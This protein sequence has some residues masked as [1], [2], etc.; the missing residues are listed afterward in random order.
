VTT[1]PEEEVP[2][3]DA[4]P[5]GAPTV[6][7][8]GPARPATDVDSAP[9]VL[10][11]REDTGEV[12]E[13]GG[14][15]APA[16]PGAMPRPALPEGTRVGRYLTLQRLGQGGMGEVYSAYDPKLDRKVAL[17][18]LLPAAGR[19]HRQ[20]GG[21][22]LEP[23]EASARL[24]REAQ[25]MAR[26]SHPNVLP[27]HDV[28]EADGRVFLAMDLVEGGT[29]R[30]WLA[31]GPRPLRQVVRAFL[32]AGKG[33]AAAHAKG[34]VHRDFKPDNV[35]VDGEGR[36]Y[37]MDFG[38]ARAAQ[39]AASA[40]GPAAPHAPP[41]AAPPAPTRRFGAEGPPLLTPP[42]LLDVALTR[43]DSLVGTPGY[44]APEQY[45]GE[46]VVPASDQ[47]AFCASLHAALYGRPAF[48]G[49]TFEEAR[50]LTL[51]GRVAPPPRGGPRVPGWLQRVI[52]RGL[53]VRPEDRFPSMAALLDALADDPAARWRRRG[54][55]AA[56]VLGLA[57]VLGAGGLEAQRERRA[58]RAAGDGL[59]AA[60][61]APA[62]A[63]VE[64]AFRATGLPY[65]QDA[66]RGVAGAL[67][68]YA[69]ALGGMAQEACLAT[70]VAGE[71]SE[72]ALALRTA[73][74]EE[75]R[76]GLA[77]L[78]DVFAHADARVVEE[79]VRAAQGLAPL[80]GCADVDRLVRQAQPPGTPGAAAH[81]LQA[82]AS[83]ARARALHASGKYPEAAG[84][85]GEALEGARALPFAP[86]EAE[87]L[88]ELGRAQAAF[89][90]HVE[91]E[92]TLAAAA[93]RGVVA[94]REDVVVQASAGLVE[95]VGAHVERAAEARQW[96]AWGSAFV[97]RAGAGT[98]TGGGGAARARA[99]LASAHGFASHVQEDYPEAERT[100]RE[101][102]AL[103]RAAWGEQ[104]QEVASVARRLATTLVWRQQHAE[105]LALHR[106]AVA[107]ME[108]AVGPEH[109]QVILPLRALGTALSLAGHSEEA[110]AFHT[111]ALRL[112]ERTLSPT[113]RGIG[114]AHNNL[115]FAL[116]Q[117]GRHAE[118]R[119]SF[120][121]SL[122]VQ[123]AAEA[124]E[125]DSLVLTLSNLADVCTALGR[126]AEARGHAARALSLGR[127]HLPPAHSALLR[128]HLALGGLELAAGRPAQAEPWLTGV[129]AHE[130]AA[131]GDPNQTF[132][133]ARLLL[134]QARWART[135]SRDA[136]LPLLAEA[137]ARLRAGAPAGAP[138]SRYLRALEAWARAQGLPLSA[139]AGPP[140]P[141]A[142]AT[143]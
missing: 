51:A 21:Q 98:G 76:D 132:A 127:A 29:L 73:C 52:L 34:L 131:R 106:Q 13:A 104:S 111:R 3:G 123:E 18:L 79:S 15:G 129:L 22:G 62:R 141:S 61:D 23:A 66:W 69:G 20:G 93:Q 54:L 90:R 137:H 113:H 44:M 49:A 89:G 121:R 72:R 1:G 38:L 68:G 27:V 43:A 6:R 74:L 48:P 59:A 120:L 8:P 84:A 140:A 114:M 95:L 11:P 97:E 36:V 107:V 100:L 77:A 30:E 57:A 5:K 119:A 65:A 117:L 55:V 130:P 124:P 14:D 71:A 126:L 143:P 39:P 31:A 110:L 133:A 105:A 37:V 82:R 80:A 118:A 94:D 128:V 60:W 142:H 115:G 116:L 70:R 4:P 135:R 83:L 67:D 41:H 35:L 139:D 12:P 86:L 50:R 91:A 134:A 101:A 75:R 45:L 103:T 102:L 81:L 63:R 33:L 7:L 138:P 108:R 64:R 46:G 96:Y 28:G 32:E 87:A 47:F 122:A 109:P 26:L 16:A 112:S 53:A 58:C 25:A 9:T 19:D 56:G 17:K 136:V 40:S 42:P 125:W 85:A 78:V 92:R 99:Q 24:L 10:R 88:L 2:A